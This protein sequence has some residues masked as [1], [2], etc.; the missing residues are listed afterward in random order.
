MN[1]KDFLDILHDYLKGTFSEMEINDILRDY[2][3]FFLNGE[4]E[5]KG[6][7]EIIKNLG[8]PKSIAKELIEE[9][10][11]PDKVNGQYKEKV[12]TE[13]KRVWSGIKSTGRKASEKG[14][15]FLDSSSIVHG[16]IS[17]TL[18]KIIM[19]LIT[20]ILIPPAIAVIGTMIV[21]G[22][23][24]IGTSLANFMGWIVSAILL[25]INLSLGVF[26]LFLCIAWTGVTIL[27]WILYALIFKGL[28]H[29]MISYIGW[30][31]KRNM[32]VRVKKNHEEKVEDYEEQSSNENNFDVMDKSDIEKAND[33]T[34]IIE[35]EYQDEELEDNPDKSYS[36]TDKKDGGEKNE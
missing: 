17:G 1:R 26:G 16:N 28:K 34:S 9:M 2:E 5:G 4:L 30:I 20:I 24:L 22:L 25:G 18:V 19:I 27:S 7:A 10:K 13:A 35:Y 6:D 31:K 11:G 12:N 23:A 3:E 29:I 14:K 21:S 33:E 36:I 15:E 8:S 32:Y